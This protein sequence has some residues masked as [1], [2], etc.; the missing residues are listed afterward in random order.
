MVGRAKRAATVDSDRTC[1]LKS[2]DRL[3]LGGFGQFPDLSGCD[4][5]PDK[6]ECID[7]TP[8]ELLNYMSHFNPG[9]SPP[10]KPYGVL[11]RK[12]TPVEPAEIGKGTMQKLWGK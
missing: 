12:P 1:E 2:I 8:K 6:Q 11:K 4:W 3:I 5:C 7:A 10:K 9:P